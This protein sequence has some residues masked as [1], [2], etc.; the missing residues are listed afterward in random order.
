[1]PPSPI[2]TENTAHHLRTAR[3]L[4]PGWL[5]ASASSWPASKIECKF[6]S[7]QLSTHPSDQHWLRIFHSHPC[8]S[9]GKRSASWH[10]S[11]KPWSTCCSRL[12]GELG[13]I[14]SSVTSACINS[15]SIY[16]Y[17]I[18]QSYFP[19]WAEELGK[20]PCIYP[21]NHK[22]DSAEWY[23]LKNSSPYGTLKSAEE[24]PS[25]KVFFKDKNNNA[26]GLEISWVTGRARF[27]KVLFRCSS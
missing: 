18:F 20:M 26:Y 1:M 21:G 24:P 16:L 13:N 3:F 23:W 12:S 19:M 6:H 11:L 27:L 8:F 2:Q 4:L 9:K 22:M 15:W 5:L 17:G 25:W 7:A 14:L 10:I